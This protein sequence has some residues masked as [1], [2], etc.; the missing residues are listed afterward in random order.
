MSPRRPRQVDWLAG[1]PRFDWVALNAS[2]HKLPR[3]ARPPLEPVLRADAPY[4]LG[5]IACSAAKLPTAALAQ[6]LY[7]GA[8]FRLSL[9]VAMQLCQRIRILSAKHGALRLDAHVEP[10][11]VSLASA[12]KHVIQRWSNLVCID[13]EPWRGQRVLCLAPASYWRHVRGARD[14]ERP[15]EGKGIGQQKAHLAALLATHTSPEHVD[16]RIQYAWVDVTPDLARTIL[17]RATMFAALAARERL[18]DARSTSLVGLHFWDTAVRYLS[19]DVL[20]SELAPV[21]EGFGDFATTSWVPAE[22][23]DERT[24]CDE[25]VLVDGAVHWSAFPTHD[26]VRVVTDLIPLDRIAACVADDTFRPTTAPVLPSNDAA[27]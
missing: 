15:L 23:S 19:S 14:W 7:T 6:A 26:D 2:V 16:S 3:P 22:D 1:D 5:V 11:D 17:R 25:M 12:E 24:E 8:L 21:L 18:A 27:S 13:L 10:Y 9:A 20:P 4:A